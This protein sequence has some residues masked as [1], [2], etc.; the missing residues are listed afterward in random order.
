MTTDKTGRIVWHDLFT[1]DR[2]RTMRFLQAIAGWD[3]VTE[4]ATDF[5]WGGGQ[6][7]FVLACAGDEAG[8]GLA[9]TPPGMP[10]GW[11][12]YVEVAD[13]DAMARCVPTLGGT[14]VR[15]PFDVPGVGRNALIRDPLGALLGLSLS[16]HDYPVPQRQFGA[17]TYLSGTGVFPAEFYRHLFGWTICAQGVI[18]GP[19]GTDVARTLHDT[20]PGDARAIWVPGLRVADPGA[21]RQA[22]EALGAR[23]LSDPPADPAPGH[24]VVLRDTGGACFCLVPTGKDIP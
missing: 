8:A 5:A 2:P 20:P 1:P 7:D 10:D 22:G 13:V 4:Q 14:V 21:A 11:I 23:R 6:K 12:A 3:F 16:R 15:P 19:S 18:S 17:E 9:E 24:R